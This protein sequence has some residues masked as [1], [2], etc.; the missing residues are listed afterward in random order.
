MQS[1][2]IRCNQ[3][4][5]RGRPACAQYGAHTR[6]TNTR[7]GEGRG[8][9]G[10]GGIEEKR[11]E[12]RA[13]AIRQHSEHKVSTQRAATKRAHGSCSSSRHRRGSHVRAS[14]VGGGGHIRRPHVA[15]AQHNRRSS[16]AAP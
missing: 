3:S 11:E 5:R 10:G 7:V 2:A 6:H 16:V 9:V 1:D 12:K 15:S 8:R 4:R 14:G 13:E